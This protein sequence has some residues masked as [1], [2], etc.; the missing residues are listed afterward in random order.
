M[1]VVDPHLHQAPGLWIDRRVPELARVHLAETLV[2]LDRLTASRLLEQPVQRLAPDAPGRR[3]LL[4]FIWTRPTIPCAPLRYR[5]L[6]DENVVGEGAREPE[7]AA[8][9]YKQPDF[10]RMM[11]GFAV[12]RSY[13]MRNGIQEYLFAR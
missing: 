2:T 10:A 1:R 4:A 12:S 13:L 5:M 8:P 3:Q 9:L 6:D 11:P 7:R